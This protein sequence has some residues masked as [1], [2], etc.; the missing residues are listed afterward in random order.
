M[1]DLTFESISFNVDYW[2]NKTEKQFTDQLKTKG[3]FS[4]SPEKAKEAFRLIKEAGKVDA[5]PAD[6]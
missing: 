3:Y 6:S 2:K 5:T 4:G 1:P